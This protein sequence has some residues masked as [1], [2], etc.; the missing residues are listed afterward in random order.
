MCID[1][2]IN[3]REKVKIREYTIKKMDKNSPLKDLRAIL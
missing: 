2:K 1:K 3:Y